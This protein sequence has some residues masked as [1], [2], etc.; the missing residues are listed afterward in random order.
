MGRITYGKNVLIQSNPTTLTILTFLPL[1]MGSITYG[2]RVL[3][4]S[5]PTTLTRVTDSYFD[6]SSLTAIGELVDIAVDLLTDYYVTWVSML[7]TYR[8]R[9]GSLVNYT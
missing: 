2:K 5:N 8:G 9:V 1:E 6:T 7:S 3:I 4:Q